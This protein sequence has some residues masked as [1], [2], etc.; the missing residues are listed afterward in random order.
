MTGS[1]VLLVDDNETLLQ[2]L[3]RLLRRRGHRVLTAGCVREAKDLAEQEIPRVVVTDLRFPDLSGIHLVEW[4][5]SR[6]R[7]LPIFVFTGMDSCRLASLCAQ[8][9]A[10][11]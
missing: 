2:T 4:L 5:R 9:G 8:Q 6:R 3:A 1:Y 11:D 10:T 7:D